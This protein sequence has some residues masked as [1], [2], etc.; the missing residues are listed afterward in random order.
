MNFGMSNGFAP[1]NLP[2]LDKLLPAVMR[3][4]YVRIYQ[5]PDSQSVTCD[6]PGYETTS[7]IRNHKPAYTNPNLTH[8]YVLSACIFP[9]CQEYLLILRRRESA[10]YKWPKNSFVNDCKWIL[11]FSIPCSLI[12]NPTATS[13]STRW[14]SSR[15]L[16]YHLHSEV[17]VESHYFLGLN[18][19]SIIEKDFLLHSKRPRYQTDSMALLYS[20]KLKLNLIC[21]YWQLVLPRRQRQPLKPQ[22]SPKDWF[23][24]HCVTIQL[25]CKFIMGRCR[26]TWGDFCNFIYCTGGTFFSLPCYLGLGWRVQ[27]LVDLSRYF[28]Y[29]YY[30]LHLLFFKDLFPRFNEN[31]QAPRSF[32]YRTYFIFQN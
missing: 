31:S 8:W 7:Y 2:G 11:Y 24:R 13:R 25:L 28:Y 27:S 30:F 3:F 5:N 6:P 15:F 14:E 4:D 23:F 21:S 29:F 9:L 26:M 18:N 1:V 19:T 22:F 16:F 32:L 12:L 20:S 10:K 17:G